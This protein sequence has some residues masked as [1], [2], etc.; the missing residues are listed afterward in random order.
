MSIIIIIMCYMNLN[1]ISIYILHNIILHSED[2]CLQYTKLYS[3]LIFAFFLNL[4]IISY[5]GILQNEYINGL[6]QIT[7]QF[8]VIVYISAVFNLRQN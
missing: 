7:V 3:D 6:N 5:P 2:Y 4:P 1:C 8:S